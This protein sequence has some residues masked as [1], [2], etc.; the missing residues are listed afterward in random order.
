MDFLFTFN[1]KIADA[2][3]VPFFMKTPLRPNHITALSLM[4]GVLAGWVVSGG[5]RSDFLVGAFFLQ[6]SFILDNCDG[7]VARLK[8]MRS[9]SGMWLDFTADLI[10]D[11]A[12][13]VGLA[14]A[15]ISRG[16]MVFHVA[17]LFAAAGAGSLINFWRVSQR[18]LKEKTGKKESSTKHPFLSAA[19]ALGNDGDPSI[20]VW[21]FA[22]FFQPI[23]LLFFGA[24]YVHFLWVSGFL[25]GNVDNN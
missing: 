4:S 16:E 22:L 2:F 3:F 8:N 17:S 10:V 13:W 15:A 6:L 11:F 20:L 14:A 19:H 12:F 5:S 21:A 7:S 24:V 9:V 18:R 1:R 23:Q 25:M